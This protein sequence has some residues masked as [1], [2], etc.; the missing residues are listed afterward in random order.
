MLQAFVAGLVSSVVVGV[1]V[2][3]GVG[4]GVCVLLVLA[5]ACRCLQVG[6]A[7][8]RF[9]RVKVGSRNLYLDRVGAKKTSGYSFRSETNGPD[10]DFV[11]KRY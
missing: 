5:G 10:Q 6:G 2:G 9:I 11:C 3:V 7:G 1:G 8:V 4:F